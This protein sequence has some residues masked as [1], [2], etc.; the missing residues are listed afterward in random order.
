MQSPLDRKPVEELIQQ[1]LDSPRS[2]LCPRYFKWG[3]ILKF[4]M[5]FA[6]PFAGLLA[7]QWQDGISILLG[8]LFQYGAS[9]W[10][11]HRGGLRLARAT[12]IVTLVLAI[13]E[14]LQTRIPGHVAEMT[15]PFMALLLG[16]GLRVL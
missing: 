4:A 10:L 14:V 12:A 3:T 1:I 6:H 16:L 8:K 11:I 13:I 7:T 9:I 15:D 2:K 5:G